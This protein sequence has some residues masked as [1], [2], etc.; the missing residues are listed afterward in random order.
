MY[1]ATIYIWREDGPGLKVCVRQELDVC[2]PDQARECLVRA[3]WAQ[4]TLKPGRYIGTYRLPDYP[5]QD[6]RRGGIT[7]I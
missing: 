3:L 6:M 2:G 5:D 4:R 1:Q 7:T